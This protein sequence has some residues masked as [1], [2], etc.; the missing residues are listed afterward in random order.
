M[1]DE[2][3]RKPALMVGLLFQIISC[4]FLIVSEQFFYFLGSLLCLGTG[5]GITLVT[6]NALL[7]EQFPKKNRGSA[8]LFL[9]FITIAGKFLAI[10]FAYVY[11]V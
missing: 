9:S 6:A 10:L 2:L 11:E 1:A 7:S 8:L 5:I 3:G 4:T